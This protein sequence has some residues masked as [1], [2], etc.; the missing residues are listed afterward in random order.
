MFLAQILRSASRLDPK[1]INTI[2][3]YMN[4]FLPFLFA[5]YLSTVFGRWWTMRTAGIGQMW[6]VVDDLCILT[7][8]NCPGEQFKAHREAMLRY[9]LLC[10]ALIYQLAR[11]E[12]DLKQLVK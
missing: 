12:P 3:K 2:S 8:V 9:G 4:A 10:Q 11:N 5:M 6:Q 1:E 7:A